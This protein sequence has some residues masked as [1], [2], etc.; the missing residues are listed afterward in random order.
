LAVR[1]KHTV[2]ARQVD[3][4][5]GHQGGQPGN[6]IQRLKDDVRGPIAVRC[7]E[8]VSAAGEPGATCRPV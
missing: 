3:A 1:G 5:L 2:E 6:K 8:P 7:L 4:W